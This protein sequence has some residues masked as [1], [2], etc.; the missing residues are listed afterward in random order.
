MAALQD[1]PDRMWPES[2]EWIVDNLRGKNLLALKHD[3]SM[4]SW[5]YLMQAAQ[6]AITEDCDVLISY[7]SNFAV[8]NPG[9]APGTLKDKVVA[10]KRYFDFATEFFDADRIQLFSPDDLEHMLENYGFDLA[11]NENF[12]AHELDGSGFKL[13]RVDPGQTLE[14]CA[15]RAIAAADKFKSPVVFVFDGGIHVVDQHSTETGVAAMAALRRFLKE[16]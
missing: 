9:D 12:V 6:L 15:G 5:S 3:N 16:N 10:H 8:A 1:E 14:V 2:A 4:G 11:A 13:M 7:G